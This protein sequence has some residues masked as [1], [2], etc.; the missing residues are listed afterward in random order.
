[1]YTNLNNI[2]E[3]LDCTTR[4]GGYLTNWYLREGLLVKFIVL[5]Q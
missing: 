5:F 2:V 4:D 1:M 3:I